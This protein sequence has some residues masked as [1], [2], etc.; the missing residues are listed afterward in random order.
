VK[1][2][3]VC[4]DDDDGRVVRT[5]GINAIMERQMFEVSGQIVEAYLGLLLCGFLAVD[6]LDVYAP[7]SDEFL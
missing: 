5:I 1:K 4:D 2:S 7:V 3:T 6:V